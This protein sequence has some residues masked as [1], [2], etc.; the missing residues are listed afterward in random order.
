MI[1]SAQLLRWRNVALLTLASPGQ[2]HPN[3]D[4]AR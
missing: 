3:K 2:G 1:L 4:L